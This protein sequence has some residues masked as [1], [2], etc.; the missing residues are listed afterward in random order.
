VRWI[1]GLGENLRLSHLT[2]T[3]C[4]QKAAQTVLKKRRNQL[5]WYDYLQVISCLG[6]P[7]V[8]RAK[9][10]YQQVKLCRSQNMR[11]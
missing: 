8:L 6:W 2:T 1:L 5:L 4:K 3:F 11:E 7:L 9:H 10:I